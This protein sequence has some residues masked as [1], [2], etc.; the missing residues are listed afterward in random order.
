MAD[1]ETGL[2]I[3][4]NAEANEA[5]AA[6]AAKDLEKKVNNSVKGGRITIPVD[7]TVPIDKDKD[8]L[9][10][11][12]SE[13]VKKINKLTSKGFS[14]SGKDIDDLNSK[15]ENFTKELDRAGKG[16]Q[17]KIFKEIR[18]QVETLEK[19]YK[20]LQQSSKISSKNNVKLK[21]QKTHNKSDDLTEEI[22][23]AIK[24]DY[25]R[26]GY[27]KF[28]KTLSKGAS[29]AKASTPGAPTNLGLRSPAMGGPYV[30]ERT[31]HMSEIS[32]YRNIDEV[33]KA[34]ELAK[35]RKKEK[36]SLT[37][38]KATTKDMEDLDQRVKQRETAGRSQSGTDYELIKKALLTDVAKMQGGLIHG[39]PDATSQKLI[40]QVLA[41]LAYDEENDVDPLKSVI[42]IHNML[43]HRY[44]TSG[45]IGVTDGTIKG[46][47]KN[48]KEANETLSHIYK[49]LGDYIE[50]RQTI[51]DIIS[52]I[53]RNS[54]QDE[55]NR[56]Q[57]SEHMKIVKELLSPVVN[58]LGNNDKLQATTKEIE[59]KIDATNK[60]IETQTNYDKIEHSAERVADSAEAKKNTDIVT[61][62]QK[63]LNTGFNT[64]AKADALINNVKAILKVLGGTPVGETTKKRYAKKKDLQDEKDVFHM[65]SAED[66]MLPMVLKT[67]LAPVGE[68]ALTVVKNALVPIEGTFKNYYE[69]KDLV[70]N[71]KRQK[72]IEREQ[73]K[74]KYKDSYNK[75][76]ESL[77]NQSKITKAFGD[78]IKNAFSSGSAVDKIMAATAEEQSKMR[79]ERIKQYGLNRGR[80]LTDT[81]DIASIRRTKEMF[82]WTYNSDKN[83]KNLFQ[84][85]K[86]TPH[87]DVNTDDIMNSLNKVLSGSEM[88]KAQTGGALRNFI[89]S[90]TGYLGMPSL[91]KS[92][93]EAEGLNQVMANVRNEVMKLLQE[94]QS[95]EFTLH[96]MEDSGEAK[97]TSDG[98][99]TD[100]SSS[101]SKKLFADLEEQKGVL[102]GVLAEVNMVDQV[103]EHTG[104][105]VHAILQ[106]LGFVMPELMQNN[107]IIKNINAGLDKNG[108]ALK[109]Q[110]R[111]AE[112][113]SYSFQLMARHI[114]Q[115]IKNW[116]MMLNPI[117]LI[118]KAFSDFASYD[119]KWQRT[120]NVVKYNLRRIIR[121]M[122]EWIAQQLVNILGLVNAIVKGVGSVLGK[123]WD[124][125]DQS[126]ANAEKMREELEAAANVSAG[127]D[128]LHDI[129]SDNSAA[130]D[131]MGDIY[132]PQW[133]GLNDFL[134]GIGE[135]IG[136]I[137]DTVSHWNFWNWLALAGAALAG[138]LALKWLIGLFTGGS[139]P[140]QTVAKGFSFLEKTVGWALLIWAFTAFTKA[141]TDF[142]ETVGKMKPEE[143]WQAFSVLAASLGVLV[144]A[145]GLLMG[146]AKLFGGGNWLNS[147]G[148]AAIV[149]SFALLTAAFAYFFDTVKS[150]SSDQLLTSL[151]A[152]AIGLALVG[153]AITALLLV[154]TAVISTGVGAVAIVAL[155]AILA[156]IASV[157]AAMALFVTAVGTYSNQLIA[158]IQAVGETITSIIQ[159]IANGISLVIS[160]VVVGIVL[161][162]QTIGN[163]IVN[164]IMGIAEG[165]QAVLEPILDF[166]D[167]IIEKIIGLAETI[168]HEIGETIRTIIETVGKIITDII[169]SLI[170]AIPTLLNAI[171]N[172]CN[173]IGP[174]I[175]NS[176][177]AIMR[178]ITK[179]INFTVSAIEYLVNLVVGG[180][181]QMISAINSVSQYVGINIPRVPEVSIPRFV[182][183]YEKGTNYVP[184][185]GLAYL[186]QGEA[187]IPK[188]YNQPYSQGM[189]AEERLYMKQM[190]NTMRSLD[191]TMKQGITVNGQFIQRGSDLVAVVNRTKSQTGADLLSNVA[192]AR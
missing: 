51:S 74:E 25:K 185:D 125:F 119:V 110:T 40:D 2:N 64:D 107:T 82:G 146:A 55:L 145:I 149:A 35:I 137:I 36:D 1:K 173:K 5:S 43:Q 33:R 50:A 182:P 37:S 44:D 88:F 133:E 68:Q 18:K 23:D 67:T 99:I 52:P 179:V 19:Q 111:T 56:I 159:A 166:I 189:S 139:N 104:G 186:H 86:L 178:T 174:A 15:F 180:V 83:N 153:A 58:N 165:I 164:I 121:P 122:M 155:A 69:G 3:S 59:N 92:R 13:V 7:I 142:I 8:K 95:K 168:A 150:M 100:D 156:A 123:N 42:G 171:L 75:L 148:I 63:D 147:L 101:A 130:G 31:L 175:E 128:E 143:V 11:A 102:R 140:L 49:I 170:N 106:N 93:V 54:Y 78:V 24:K 97:F 118:K 80:D 116:M 38:H 39:R 163:T 176:A 103:V 129:G 57:S 154:L 89:G 183:K 188:K 48:Q 47:G 45:K 30:D 6:K 62:I 61:G 113:L 134:E 157:I 181:N 115:I 141:L 27:D 162:I 184:S 79:A 127:F 70:K 151:S 138:F 20:E 76:A 41:N 192:Y 190:M 73:A 60:A 91:E 112:V 114:G 22:N 84:N 132:T 108:K 158:V 98:Y 87:E 161:T 10:Q 16:R 160:T 72:E 77:P 177:D 90:F 135:T 21:K 53:K 66:R 105:S 169:T 4:V 9:S 81:G 96:G 191:D 26:K 12:Q 187:V 65:K 17:N 124:L 172:F 136:H 109:F 85:V 120:M 28:S 167:D 131:L 144:V 34:K 71:Q 126:A 94:I 29:R 14:A 117:N 32:P 46:E 152:L